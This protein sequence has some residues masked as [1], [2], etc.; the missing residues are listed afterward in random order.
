MVFKSS[1]LSI[2]SSKRSPLCAMVSVVKKDIRFNRNFL[3]TR[4]LVFR[5]FYLM[6]FHSFPVSTYVRKTKTNYNDRDQRLEIMSAQLCKM[7]RTNN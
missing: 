4:Q 2:K 3:Q 5:H 7:G 6:I 1:A